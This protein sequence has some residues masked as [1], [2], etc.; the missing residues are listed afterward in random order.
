MNLKSKTYM[1][2]TEF[3]ERQ[4]WLPFADAVG[5]ALQVMSDVKESADEW[6]KE[7]KKEIRKGWQIPA[8]PTAFQLFLPFDLIIVKK[9]PLL[10]NAA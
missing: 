8:V 3:K 2:G 9:H 10:K 7:W 6:F 5:I 1:K 4:F